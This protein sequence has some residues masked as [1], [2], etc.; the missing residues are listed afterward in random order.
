MCSSPRQIQGEELLAVENLVCS[1]PVITSS[2]RTSPPDDS[3]S[4][5]M[6]TEDFSEPFG[7][8]SLGL[9]DE[10]GN[11]VDLECSIGEP[12]QLTK[13]HWEQ[14]NQL[15]LASNITLSLD[16]ECPVDR[17]KYE[18]LWRLIAYYSDVPAHL[19]TRHQTVF[20]L[21]VSPKPSS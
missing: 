5:V 8:I 6:T 4:E 11:E 3:E 13:I 12:R 20:S 9:S 17:E 7:N 16:I 14:I 10:H 19:Q 1:S 18:R 15:Q 2:L 21:S